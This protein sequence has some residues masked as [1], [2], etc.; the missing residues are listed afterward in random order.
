MKKHFISKRVAGILTAALIT[1][2]GISLLTPPLNSDN[3]VLNLLFSKNSNSYLTA[4]AA[5][6][7]ADNS[8]ELSSSDITVTSNGTVTK[9]KPNNFN[10][11]T[12]NVIKV[13]FNSTLNIKKIDNNVFSDKFSGKKVIL[14][15][16]DTL[17]E[18]GEDAFSI[19]GI[20]AIKFNDKLRI[21]GKSAF[22]ANPSLTNLKL[23]RDLISIGDSAFR[24]NTYDSQPS[25]SSVEF[26]DNL[27]TIGRFA[28]E[29]QTALTSSLSFGS[30]LI[31]IGESAFENTRL[32]SVKVGRNVQKIGENAFNNIPSLTS[33]DFS[34]ANSLEEIGDTAFAQN[35]NYDNW[36]NS[37]LG[38]T[39]DIILPDSVKKIGMYAF[40]FNNISKVKLPNS[41]E[42][43]GSQAFKYNAIKHIDWGNYDKVNITVQDGNSK[44]NLSYPDSAYT[45][46]AIPEEL[47]FENQLETVNIPETVVTIGQSAFSN[48]KLKDNL[49]IPNSV[50]HIYSAAFCNNDYDKTLT[51][52]KDSSG[53][54]NIETIGYTTFQ[55]CGIL[56]TDSTG[57]FTIPDSVKHIDDDSFS[58]NKIKNIDFNGTAP[59]LLESSFAEN[60]LINIKNLNMSNP[61]MSNP[62]DTYG[63]M[64]FDDSVNK[65]LK[66]VDFNYSN[67]HNNFNYL[68]FS[69]FSN[70]SLRSILFPKNISDIK[71][72]GNSGN[73][74]YNNKG[75]YD[76]TNKVALYRVDSN[77][78][79]V[80]DNSLDDSSAKYY[81]FNPVLLEFN[82]TDKDG[83]NYDIQPKDVTIKRTNK[84]DIN[85]STIQTKDYTNF[86]LG[87]EITFK[88]KLTDALKGYEL[89]NPGLE[90]LGDDK[91]KI[92]LNPERTDVVIDTPY[93][94]S[95]YAIGYKKTVI[96]LKVKSSDG[97]GDT[98]EEKNPNKND[99]KKDD[100]KDNKQDDNNKDN[101]KDSATKDNNEDKK[102][103]SKKDTTKDNKSNKQDNNDTPDNT[104]TNNTDS[105]NQVTNP[106]V[107]PNDDAV[108]N[109]VDENGNPLGK[110]ILDKDTGTYTLIDDDNRTPQGIAKINK[111]NTLEVIK[112]FN[113]KSPLGTLPKTGGNG[114]S[115]VVLLGASLIGLGIFIRK[116]LK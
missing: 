111:D 45:G 7:I 38:I 75:W 32:T 110:A 34:E 86:K 102:E 98:K 21:I 69:V 63:R 29:G 9:F 76:G 106:E 39:G 52:N 40:A 54:Y 3:T 90:R 116:K 23:G 96:S 22:Y 70:G 71:Y 60:P 108:F 5:S 18:I 49:V 99:D 85:L 10:A 13:S 26:N 114:D 48:N 92:V 11:L 104:T 81:V 41:L 58:R 103:P 61:N 113:D 14:E 87:D 46:I 47:F 105:S 112:I 56:G 43:I 95:E 84:V 107:I 55:E 2:G 97:S 79:Y 68:H 1:T 31:S 36:K 109:L 74:F 77:K 28:F 6:P 100:K 72:T 15:L 80:L 16:P 17:E 101:K 20:V 12:G 59:T 78:K 65:S 4:E 73:A 42:N 24:H 51:F 19:N 27:Q 93:D 115:S 35:Q 64:L 50:K 8:I 33:V 89:S 37:K 62:N 91:Y 44:P 66:N 25:L 82:L 57:L 94:D 30:G 88:L 53:K 67:L 83:Q